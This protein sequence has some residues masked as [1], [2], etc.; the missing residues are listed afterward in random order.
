MINDYRFSFVKIIYFELIYLLKGYRGYRFEFTEDNAFTDNIPCPYYFLLKIKKILKNKNFQVFMD[1][2]CGSGRVINFLN[3]NMNNKDF[4]GIELSLNSYNYC[5]KKFSNNSNIQIL[6]EDFTKLNFLKHQADCYFLNHPIKNDD[7]LIKLLRKIINYHKNIK[8]FLLIL[9]NCHDSTLNFLKDF[10]R[11]DS[12]Y[13]GKKRGY[14]IFGI[15][16]TD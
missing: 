12:Y 6:N 4:F 16:K 5:K 2:G 1:L 7:E 10:K 9:V 3:R 14:S 8:D 15:S 11:V 13:I